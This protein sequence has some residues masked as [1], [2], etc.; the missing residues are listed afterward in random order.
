VKQDVMP[1]E[2][3]TAVRTVFAQSV[4]DSGYDGVP[5]P[6]W[7]HHRPAL[8]V[9]Q[10]PEIHRP[11]EAGHGWSASAV[12]SDAR[13]HPG[14]ALA[15]EGRQTTI[16]GPDGQWF[17]GRPLLTRDWFR[18]ARAQR[19]VLLISGPFA[20]IDQFAAAASTGALRLLLVAV[21]TAP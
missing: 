3:Y 11:I 6:E 13:P 18:A 12:D 9:P 4:L 14:W 19:G 2:A 1:M 10:L 15:L 7:L 16:T 5:W 17:R 8:V 21:R 20:R